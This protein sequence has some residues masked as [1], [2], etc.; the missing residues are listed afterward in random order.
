MSMRVAV[1]GGTGTAGRHVVEH[2]QRAGHDVLVLSRARGVDVRSGAERG[3]RHI[4]A[5]S[6]VGIDRAGPGYFAAK[7][8]HELALTAGPVATTV[9][10]A[11][12]FHEFPAKLISW[13]RSGAEAHVLDLHVQPV[14]AR[15]VG[16]VLVELAESEPAGRAGELAGPEEDD[17]VALAR[18]FVAHRGADIAIHPAPASVPAQALIPG[19]GARIAGPA[20]TEWLHSEDAAAL[21]L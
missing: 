17:L 14:A 12:Q 19:D 9:L 15:T 3:V 10:R 7:L 1:A 6:I 13:T 16:E 11:T 4:V 2:A 5:L 8:A 21:P 20:F 18:A